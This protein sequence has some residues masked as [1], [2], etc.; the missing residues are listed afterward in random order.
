MVEL[1][2]AM[3]VALMGFSEVVEMAGSMATGLVFHWVE[4][5]ADSLAAL[6][7]ARSVD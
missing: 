7:V 2:V 5:L 6:S 3:L 4:H 1:M